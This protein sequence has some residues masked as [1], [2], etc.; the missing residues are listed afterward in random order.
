MLVMRGQQSPFMILDV[1]RTH[2]EHLNPVSN[3]KGID[4]WKVRSLLGF[5]GQGLQL[6]S[7]FLRPTKRLDTSIFVFA[8]T[9]LAANTINMI[10]DH[11]QQADDPHQLHFL[12]QR[13]NRELTPHLK[14]GEAPISIEEKRAQLREADEPRKP[15]D[16]AKGFLRRH[17]VAVGELGLRY[18]GAVGLAFP[19]RWW[20]EIPKAGL[21]AK[22]DPSNYRVYSGL[23]SIFGKTVALSAQIPDPYNPKPETWIDHIRER[24]SFLAGGMIEVTSFSA[25]A[26]SCFFKT[27]HNN[28]NQGIEVFGRRYPD[29]LGGIGATLF[30]LGYIARSWAKFGER[31]VDMNELYAHASDTL[32]A[33]PPEK[34]P[35]LLANTSA[36]LSEH[37]D[38]SDELPFSIIYSNLLSDLTRY[39]A[40][41]IRSSLTKKANEPSVRPVFTPQTAIT[42]ND[43]SP[44]PRIMATHAELLPT[45]HSEPL[46]TFAS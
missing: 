10:Y 23:S 41:V 17:S 34:L 40:A 8:A 33:T 44:V 16:T 19:A 32:A 12:K 1:L 2:G 18:M 36:S 4:P 43:A 46:K 7:S 20:K 25:L 14:A 21:W 37:F 22:R 24:W 31:K 15:L 35:E 45:I 28:Y 29:I 13:I 26:Y 39:H 6:V 42:L 3:K 38:R 9:N 11:G 30:V 5:G 27:S